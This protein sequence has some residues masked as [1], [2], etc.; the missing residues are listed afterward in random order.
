MTNIKIVH[1]ND[2]HSHFE[3][4]PKIERFISKKRKSAK[5]NNEEFLLFDIGDFSDRQHPLTEAT[6]GKAN[7]QWLNDQGYDAVTIGNNEGLGNSYNQLNNMFTDAKFPVIIGNLKSLKTNEIPHFATEYKIYEFDD[8]K[9]GVLGLTFPY[10]L[11]YPL[12]GW[13]IQLIQDVLQE[14]VDELKEEG[15]GVVILLSHLGISMDRRIANKFNNIDL[16]I[17]SH[18]HHLF[19]KGELD[20]KTYLAAADRYGQY[21]GEINLSIENNK[22]SSIS[23]DTTKT[24]KIPSIDSDENK[25]EEYL[26]KGHEILRKKEVVRLTYD[27]TNDFES[28]HSNIKYAL[29]AIKKVTDSDVAVLNNGLFLKELNKGVV[30]KDDIHDLLPH[31]MHVMKVTLNGQETWRLFLEMEFNRLFLRRHIQKGMGFRGKYFGELVYDGVKVNLDKR[32]V[33]IK[34][35]PID[36]DKMYTI[37][38]LDHYLFLPYFPTIKIMGENKLYY[39][40]FIRDVYSDYLKNKFGK[41]NE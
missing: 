33:L 24:E 19:E 37:A 4:F 36:L 22:L 39:P 26:K 16:I 31:A 18:T 6:D 30:T 11:T 40:T 38:T 2:L 13:D 28:E 32:T 17:G 9:I 29:K 25:I 1:T 23:L 41:K 7:I 3:N 27:L 35:K 8:N 21:I 12:I 10:V 34:D 5:L 15:C 20:N 14:Q